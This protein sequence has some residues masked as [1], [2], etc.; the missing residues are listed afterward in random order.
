MY[1][2]RG[3]NNC[4]SFFLVTL[5][6]DPCFACTCTDLVEHMKSLYLLGLLYIPI[7]IAEAV[8]SE[9]MINKSNY[10]QMSTIVYYQ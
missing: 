7:A 1:K 5:S 2:K 9:S 6:V 3:T 10:Q 8:M 4:P